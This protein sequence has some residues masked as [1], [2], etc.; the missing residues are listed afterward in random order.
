M[1]KF[2][3]RDT[4]NK[5]KFYRDKVKLIRNRNLHTWDDG[6][7]QV[8]SLRLQG[9][10]KSGTS[11]DELLVDAYALVCEVAKRKLGLQPYDTQIMAAIALHEKFLIGSI[12]VKE[13]RS[14]R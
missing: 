3:N 7:L 11:L 5:L 4:Q 1:L 10:A 9:E 12:L 2:K 6:Q 8:E 14:L 13:K